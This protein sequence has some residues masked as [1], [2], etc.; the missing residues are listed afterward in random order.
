[1]STNQRMPPATWIKSSEQKPEKYWEVLGWLEYKECIGIVQLEDDN[2]WHHDEYGEVSVT[3]WMHLPKAP[4][5][6]DS[7]GQSAPFQ[8]EAVEILTTLCHLKHYKDTVGKD[9]FYEREQPKAW[10]RA[11]SFLD[12]II[13]KK[14]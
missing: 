5:K 11:N 13:S 1:M 6:E 2:E 12:S 10:Q 7:P 3:H 9:S 4:G 8:N 14:Q